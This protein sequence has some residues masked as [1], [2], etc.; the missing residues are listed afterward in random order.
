MT[1]VVVLA[2]TASA[3]ADVNA[4]TVE[5]L[6][7]VTIA[8]E[9]AS[10]SASAV[11]P[12]VSTVSA[13]V[14]A[15][16]TSY[17]AA[18]ALAPGIGTAVQPPSASATW[19]I[20]IGG[21]DYS[22]VIDIGTVSVRD[23]E[24]KEID[25]L[26]FEVVDE[27]KIIDVV[28]WR[29]VVFTLNPG[30]ADEIVWF[31]GYVVD[32][33]RRFSR[34]GVGRRLTVRCEGYI[35]ALHRC[36]VPHRVY[37]DQ[38]PAYI[39]GD[40]FMEGG[41]IGFDCYSHVA[42]SWPLGSF[43]VDRE[44]KLASAIE[45]LAERLGWVWRVDAA[46]ALWLGPATQDS[47][48][49]ALGEAG[50]CNYSTIFPVQAGSESFG[51]SGV[52]LINKVVIDGGLYPSDET[53]DNFTGTGSQYRFNLS[54]RDIVDIRVLLNGEPVYDGTV[55]W[56][57]YDERDVL[58]NYAEGWIEFGVVPAAGA[59]IQAIYRYY[60]PYSYS[61]QDAA[62]IASYG[63]HVKR[64][65]RAD[66]TEEG[67][68]AALAAAILAEF[69]QPA[70]TGSFLVRQLGLRAGQRLSCLFPSLGVSAGLTVRSLL[71]TI[72][73]DFESLEC[74]VQVGGRSTRLSDLIG[75]SGGSGGSTLPPGSGTMVGDNRVQ[76]VIL[77]IN[78][79][80][81]WSPP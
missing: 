52:E 68:A 27:A 30:T 37:V 67:E 14:I 60:T 49:F 28:F 16:P 6:R 4:P 73:P 10:G 9:V 72:G 70:T 64:V 11:A 29:E 79:A 12:A 5:A 1:D 34:S 69:S 45:R 80:T 39:V 19:R 43:S 46:K 53:T 25:T 38:T 56:H 61:A 41:L 24:G 66:I 77:A 8:G 40:L 2:V 33:R 47:A 74:Q 59:A 22:T 13:V 15:V 76:G 75:G 51:F 17:A 35:S 21:T 18:S 31:G 78:P 48:P 57:N 63:T 71:A 58:T 32:V 36:E 81:T 23:A 50:Q 26:S 54:H 7:Y 55:G 20:T 62:S 3:D 65:A 42:D 44:E